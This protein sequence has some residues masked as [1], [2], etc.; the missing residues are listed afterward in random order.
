MYRSFS[1]YHLKHTF[2]KCM[3]YVFNECFFVNVSEIKKNCCVFE[4]D[5]SFVLVF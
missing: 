4:I 5:V 2:E 3:S 1:I